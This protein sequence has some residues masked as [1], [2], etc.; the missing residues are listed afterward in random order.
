[1][2]RQSKEVCGW[3]SN[4]HSGKFRLFGAAIVA[5]HEIVDPRTST[6][7][8][9]S[10]IIQVLPEQVASQIAAG[11]VVE[12]PA[13]AVKELIENSLDA[14][15]RRLSIEVAGGGRSLIAVGDDGCGMSPADVRLCLRRHATSKIRTLADLNRIRSFGFRG[16]ALAS[17][18]SVSRLAVKTRRAQDPC[19]MMLRALGGDMV[20]SAECAMAPGTRVEARDL[21]FNTPARLKFLKTV[22][23][24]QAAIIDCV[25]RLALANFEAAFSLTGDERQVLELPPASALL[26]RIRQLFGDEIARALLAFEAAGAEMTVRGF[27]AHSQISFAGARMI[28][29]YVNQRPVRDR[30]LARSVSQAYAGLLPRGRYPAVMLFVE[31]PAREVDVNVHPMKTEIRFRRSG[32][33][34]EAV[35]RVLRDRLAN[36]VPYAPPVAANEWSGKSDREST[37]PD[38]NR[39]PAGMSAPVRADDFATRAGGAAQPLDAQAKSGGLRLIIDNAPSRHGEVRVP[40]GAREPMAEQG[41]IESGAAVV[42]T[43]S[44]ALPCYSELRLLGQ[45][46][47]GYIV[48]EQDDGLLLVDQHAAHERVTFEKL[49]AELAGGGVRVQARLVA[50]PLELSAA[51]AGEVLAALPALRALGFDVEP[52]GPRSIVVK[53][54]PA[55]FAPSEGLRLL[56]DLIEGVGEEGLAA[57]S[58]SAFELKLKLI[59]CHGSIR[60]GRALTEPEM[61]RLLEELDR[62]PFKTNCPHG[63]PVHIR[64]GLAQIERMFRR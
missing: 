45:F 4:L 47:A 52:F 49:R 63:R 30:L 12:R 50:E 56:S 24:E 1:M 54:T 57:D 22:A 36:Q 27:A 31:L 2:E 53:G 61:R 58:A 18:A 37:S 64:F 19:G 35:Y 33:V 17:L 26:E 5:Q 14:G 8:A 3:K 16:E 41:Q 40:A 7:M 43:R 46:L 29:T 10:G 42:P 21:F 28:F 62:A 6:L 55:L 11:E 15:A 44:E 32:A 13:S 34:F 25:Q 48:L 20:D 23:T 38:L 9:E 51:G 60:V 59:A 39:A